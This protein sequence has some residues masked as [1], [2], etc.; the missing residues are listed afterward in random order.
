MEL[1]EETVEQE[2]FEA[3]V[4]GDPSQ[5]IDED[6]ADPESLEQHNGDETISDEDGD[7]DFPAEQVAEAD[8]AEEEEH[9]DQRPGEKRLRVFISY[10][11]NDN[12]GAIAERIYDELGQQY[13]VFLDRRTIRIGEPYEEVT[14]HWL[15]TSD[16]VIALISAKSVET[17]FIKA[18]L[19]RAYERYK[20]EARPIVI[21]LRINYAGPSGLRLD[22][23]IGHFQRI[24]WDNKNFDWLLEQLHAGLSNKL[25]GITK[26]VITGTDIIPISDTLRE[27]YAQAF[28]EPRELINAPVSF[29]EERLLW[30]SGDPAVTNYVALSMAATMT[31]KSLY[32]ITKQRKWSEINRTLISDSTIVLRDALPA[33]YLEESGAIGEWHALRA[34][35]ER[36][37]IIIATAPDDEFKKLQ[38][39]LLRYQFTDYQHRQVDAGSY[40]DDSKLLIFSRLIEHLFKTGELDEDKYAWAVDL[41]KD[42]N[43]TDPGGHGRARAI[44]RRRRDM[45]KKFRENLGRWSPADLLRFVLSLSQV[46]S[47]SD[48]ARLLQRSAAIEDEIRSWFLALDDST[49]CFVMTV[50]LFANLDHQDLWEYYKSV[51][52]HLRH[53]D[54][55]LSLLPFGICRKRAHPYVSLD[56]PIAL[57]ERVADAVRQEIARSY[58]EYFVELTPILKGWSVPPG[59]SPKTIEQRNQRKP[60]IEETRTARMA[61]ARMVGIAARLGLDD[62][63]EILDYWATDSNIQI[64]KSVALAFAETARSPTGVNYALNI[65]ERW[66]L[67]INSHGQTRWRALAAAH[68]LGFVTAAAND[69]Y[70]TLRALHCLRTFARSRRPDARF[71]ASIALRQVARFAPLSSTEGALGRLAKDDRTEVRMNVAAALNESRAYDADT[72][73][74]LIERWVL[75]DDPNRRWVALCGIVTSRKSQNGTSPNKYERLLDFL[76]SE[77]SALSLAS[78]LGETVTD[79]HY[80]QVARDTFSYLVE[81]SQDRAWDNLA[82]ALGAVPVGKLEKELLPLLHFDTAPLFDERAI[83]VRREVLRKK[84]DDPPHFLSILK[85][86]LSREQLRLEVF[87]ALTML[88][89]ESL[90]SARAQFMGTMADYFSQNASG[91]NEMLTALEALAPGHFALLRRAVIREAFRRV[92]QDPP[93][94]LSLTEKQ[95]A[96]EATSDA[97]RDAIMALV[98]NDPPGSREAMLR[99]LLECHTQS[100]DATRSL[101]SALGTTASLDLT[102]AVH[103]FNYRVIE[104]AMATPASFPS[105]ALGMVQRDSQIFSLLNYLAAPEPQGQRSNLVRA[106]VE[107]RLME[108]PAAEEFLAL[109]ALKEWV[110]L[111]SIAPEVA[112]SFY[113]RKVFSRKFVRR[114]FTRKL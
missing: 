103:E 89:D 5:P 8:Q 87:R 55:N 86:W 72:A 106:L 109:P 88:L 82:S 104:A 28:V 47:E 57:D 61:I 85:S 35:I 102:T 113:V 110:N 29:D 112:R 20:A 41:V 50:A 56:G 80:G 16:F 40:S 74:T 99:T 63:I 12:D 3:H 105:T 44:E 65:L 114:L 95:L 71:Y 18:E 73:D 75:S 48:I 79:D 39:E 26:A 46:D 30:I 45:R 19:Q 4:A 1:P 90:E 17:S 23:Y 2:L 27:R 84:L 81:K 67:D 100:P 58:R 93:K 51:V 37:N 92:L 15:D 33:S 101:L 59:R 43:E 69:A 10:N 25:A 108:L 9:E 42:P 21:P 54:A 22:A 14:E 34:I 32:E 62:L 52:E 68:A 91:V 78:V 94:F 7:A 98:S 64:R 38:Q 70:V 111:A 13:D 36:N 83:E 49:R 31:D 53:L 77:E 107:A 6:G 76:D 97:T 24:D 11:R 96:H 66:S 60:K